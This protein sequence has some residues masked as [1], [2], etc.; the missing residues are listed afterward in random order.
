MTKAATQHSCPSG[1]A[2]SACSVVLIDGV[3]HLRLGDACE[4]WS[5]FQA[6]DGPVRSGQV[7]LDETAGRLSFQGRTVALTRVEFRL[8]SALARERGRLL[9]YDETASLVWG[10][11]GP[12]TTLLRAHVR[13]IRVK[14]RA[15]G[16]PDQL[17]ESVRGHGLRLSAHACDS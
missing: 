16:L 15:A 1:E 6:Q 12:S 10:P 11:N 7:F 17:I 8:V 13:N 3:P 4:L 14:L 9:S 5:Y 2:Q